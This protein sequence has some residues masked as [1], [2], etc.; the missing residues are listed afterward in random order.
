MKNKFPIFSNNKNLVYLDSA[1]TAQKPKAVIDAMTI[2]YEN[3]NA[4]INRGAY[5]LSDTSSKLYERGREDNKRFINA[6]HSNEVIF[7]K[8]T[9]ESINIVATSYGMTNIKGGDEVAL[10]ISEHHSN[11]L[12]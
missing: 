8:G 2:Y 7:T 3:Y 6:R 1:A 4:N 5:A 9:T 12:P 10:L 11:V